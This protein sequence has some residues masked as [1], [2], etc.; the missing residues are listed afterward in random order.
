MGYT[1]I[2]KEQFLDVYARV[3]QDVYESEMICGFCY[4][5]LADIEQEVNGLLTEEHEYKFEPEQIRGDLWICQKGIES[6]NNLRIANR[7]QSVKT[8]SFLSAQL[9]AEEV[10][11]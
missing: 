8:L 11:H 9:Y 6:R 5:Q 7:R 1:S 10:C 4:T 3:L 2:G